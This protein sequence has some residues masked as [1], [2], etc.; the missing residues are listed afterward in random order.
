MSLLQKYLSQ[1]INSAHWFVSMGEHA[2]MTVVCVPQGM[3]NF[4]VKTR[5]VSLFVCVAAFVAI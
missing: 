1:V 5:E 2:L 4:S 3:V